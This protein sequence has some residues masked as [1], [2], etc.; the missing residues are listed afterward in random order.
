VKLC[1]DCGHT[2]PDSY[3]FCLGCGSD[4]AAQSS[5]PAA[6]DPPPR[7]ALP[8]H[9]ALPAQGVYWR[10]T[11][12]GDDCRVAAA[13]EG[14]LAPAEVCPLPGLYLQPR[15]GAVG[16]VLSAYKRLVR[17]L[18]WLLYL[19]P[20]LLVPKIVLL[21]FPQRIGTLLIG[22]VITVA[23]V[24]LL[25]VFFAVLAALL[26]LVAL[27]GPRSRRSKGWAVSPPGDVPLARALAALS[28]ARMRTPDARRLHAI[29]D[30]LLKGGEA[31]PTPLQLRGRV[32]R[33]GSAPGDL[34]SD[35]WFEYP[36]G[37]VREL[38]GLPFLLVDEGQPPIVIVPG[39]ATTLLAPYRH[40]TGARPV[41]PPVDDSPPRAS[42]CF[43][44]VEGQRVE[45]C[46]WEGR[47]EP[48]LR[49]LRLEGV[50]CRVD[51]VEKGPYR[52]RG[53]QPA[54]IVTCSAAP[55]LVRAL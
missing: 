44:L 55:L 39:A 51:D 5:D 27:A 1:R 32:E 41:V 16:A 24:G 12:V 30:E 47:A 4:L 7:D 53:L 20:V 26:A 15:T 33:F 34:L 35:R 18:V 46:A 19:F 9:A 37:I 8:A 49:E 21:F 40:D 29:V 43:T 42:Y 6:L 50:A 17:L 48:D 11:I 10:Q 28:P 38:A 3:R 23:W 31:A 25:V 13:R 14:R 2:N 54:L 36:S 45:L 22:D 52:G